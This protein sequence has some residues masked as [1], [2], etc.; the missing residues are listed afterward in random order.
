MRPR[1]PPKL[2]NHLSS[3]SL[4]PATFPDDERPDFGARRAQR[5]KLAA[6]DDR[7]SSVNAD[8]KAVDARRDLADLAGQK[9]TLLEVAVNKLQYPLRIRANGGPKNR[10][11]A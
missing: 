6:R 2:V 5:R 11:A 3:Q 9:A 10:G 8:H 7:A 4:A 1:T